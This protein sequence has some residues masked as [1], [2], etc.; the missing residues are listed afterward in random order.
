MMYIGE[1]LNNQLKMKLPPFKIDVSEIIQYN[2][3]QNNNVIKLNKRK[4]F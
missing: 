1:S 2:T 3:K 4:I